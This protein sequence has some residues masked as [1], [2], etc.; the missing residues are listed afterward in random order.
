MP[1][2]DISV[3]SLVQVDCSCTES[4]KRDT[5]SS[6]VLSQQCGYPFAAEYIDAGYC[7]CKVV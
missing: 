1:F 3:V 6:Q 4:P 7:K 2:S 5:G